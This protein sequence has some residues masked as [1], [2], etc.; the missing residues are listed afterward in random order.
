MPEVVSPRV[1]C[2]TEQQ[3]CVEYDPAYHYE[4]DYAHSHYLC[5]V[6]A[7]SDQSE[8]KKYFGGSA[9]SFAAG[10]VDLYCERTMGNTDCSI[11][12][13]PS[14]LARYSTTQFQ[15]SS[16]L[17]QPATGMSHSYGDVD[18]AQYSGGDPNRLSFGLKCSSDSGGTSCNAEYYPSQMKG[19][20]I[21]TI[22]SDKYLCKATPWGSECYGPYSGGDPAYVILGLP[23]YYCDDNGCGRSNYP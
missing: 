13:Y 1:W 10:G 21:A 9:P 4:V 18:C 8:C 22:G 6:Q 17:C 2:S 20:S 19:V 15:G 11:E 12:W 5:D 16:Y 7:L 14:Q 3:L 23:D